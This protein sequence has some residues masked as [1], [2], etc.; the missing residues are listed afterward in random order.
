MIWLLTLN[1]RIFDFGRNLF[2]KRLF[3]RELNDRSIDFLNNRLFKEMLLKRFLL[4]LLWNS[5]WKMFD[6]S[7]CLQSFRL[8]LSLFKFF[9]HQLCLWNLLAFVSRQFLSH[10]FTSVLLIL[11]PDSPRIFTLENIK[12][13]QRKNMWFANCLSAYLFWIFLWSRRIF[14]VVSDLFFYV[15]HKLLRSKEWIS[16]E[17]RFSCVLFR[18]GMTRGV[19]NWSIVRKW[20]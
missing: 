3:L 4:T 19:G 18:I 14:A 1:S 13:L 8:K 2:Q 7:W 20:M 15:V 17:S 11:L 5:G 6:F 9:K 16:K 10:R 12:C